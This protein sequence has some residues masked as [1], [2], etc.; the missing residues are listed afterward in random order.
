MAIVDFSVSFCLLVFLLGLTR[1]TDLNETAQGACEDLKN[2]RG[3]ATI[4][5][6]TAGYL[7]LSTENWSSTA[8]ATP[9]CIFQPSHASDLKQ[10]VGILVKSKVSFAIR[11]GG[12][13]PSPLAANSNDGVLIDLSGL[14]QTFYDAASQ[15]VTIGAGLRWQDVYHYLDQFKVTVVGGRVLDVGVG[16]LLLGSGL[17]YLSDLYGMA[18]DNVVNYEV[19]LADGSIVNANASSHTDLFWGL[20]GGANNFGIVASF[21][22][23]TYPI[24]QVWGG[25]KSYSTD[26]VPALL[27]ALMK[28]QSSPNKDPYANL[29][30]QPFANNRSI[31]AVL[32]LVYLKPEV[33]PAAFQPFYSIPTTS[34][35]TKLQTLTEMMSG[36]MVPGISRWDWFATSFKPTSALYKKIWSIATST[37]ELLKIQDIMSGTLVLGFQPISSSLVEAGVARGGNALGLSRVNQTWLVLDVGW[38]NAKDDFSAHSATGSILNKIVSETKSSGK[39]LPY[40]FMNDASWDQKVIESYG[41]VQVTKLKLARQ[42]YDPS[43]VFTRLVRGGFKLPES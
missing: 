16:G 35:S 25:I 4:L 18:C 41:H 12:H 21:T 22:L 10:A 8:W 39:A 27:E 28:Y 2:I 1:A 19:I 42:R 24:H 23:R 26:D 30:L 33:S 36:Q 3:G 34:D 40:I 11:S 32:N 5:P 14:N 6:S 20:K 15:V 37:P 43:L 17:S 9:I 38:S 31:G 7:E 13:S 29:M